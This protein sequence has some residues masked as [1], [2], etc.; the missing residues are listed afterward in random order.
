VLA[1][2]AH[3]YVLLALHATSG[4]SFLLVDGN[5]QCSLNAE[6]AADV[7]G[8]NFRGRPDAVLVHR[9]A[10]LAPQVLLRAC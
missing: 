3:V 7:L 1:P 9:S 6:G 2:S 10:R 8:Y 4:R 5:K